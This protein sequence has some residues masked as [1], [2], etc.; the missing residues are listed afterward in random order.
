MRQ[1]EVQDIHHKQ[2]GADREG[3]ECVVVSDRVM[4]DKSKAGGALLRIS[5]RQ[6]S[7][8]SIRRSVYLST[9][10]FP[11]HDSCSVVR[12]CRIAQLRAYKLV[13]GEH[14]VAARLAR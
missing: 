1:P 4:A 3:G 2:S 7:R 8:L 12:C 10:Q 11:D 9:R 13:I 6:V 14:T 5:V